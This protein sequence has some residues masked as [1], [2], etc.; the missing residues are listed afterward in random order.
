[1]A[2][3]ACIFMIRERHRLGMSRAVWLLIPLSFLVAIAFTFP[4]FLAWREHHL[5]HAAASGPVGPE[6]V[7]A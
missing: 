5:L 4:L 7:T 2:V 3:V 1:V 6:P